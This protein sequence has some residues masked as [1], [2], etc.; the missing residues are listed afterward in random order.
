MIGVSAMPQA[1][2]SRPSRR[3]TRA[4]RRSAFVEAA[5]R[6]FDQLED[7]CDQHPD[8]S[9]GEIEVE[10]RQRRRDLMGSGLGVLISG[11]EAGDHSAPPR[12]PACGQPMMFADYRSR[13][14]Y[15]LEGDTELSR[16]YSV[17]SQCAG[18]TLFPPGPE[19][20]AAR[21]PLE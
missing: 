2:P 17:C 6:M 20:A 14:V 19:T 11:R 3:L 4:Q 15:G 9:F 10:A 12:C 7:W 1:S 16:G 8:A 5:G 13:T 21:R 18:Q